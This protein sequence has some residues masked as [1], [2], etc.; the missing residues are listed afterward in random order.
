MNQ[1]L[2]RLEMTPLNLLFRIGQINLQKS[3]MASAG[4]N[5]RSYHVVLM[6]EPYMYKKNE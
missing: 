6:T 4:L 1:E 3:K 2:I 5:S